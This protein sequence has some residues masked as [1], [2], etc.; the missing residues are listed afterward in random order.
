MDKH[1]TEIEFFEYANELIEDKVQ[2]SIIDAHLSSCKNC[3]QTLL[4]EQKIDESI[5]DNLSVNHTVDLSE[6]VVH[7]FTQEKS[8]FLKVDVKGIITV[9]LLFAGL[10]LLNQLVLSLKEINIPYVNLISSAVIGLFFVELG[11]TY[12]KY[13]KKVNTI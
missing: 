2:L 6:N 7:Y 10:M 5:K 1:L 3:Q 12:I 8:F 4:L 9:L 11:L 13:K